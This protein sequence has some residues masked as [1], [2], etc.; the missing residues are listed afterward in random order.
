MAPQKKHVWISQPA[1]CTAFSSGPA[2]RQP[3]DR[4]TALHKTRPPQTWPASAAT[5]RHRHSGYP[6]TPLVSIGNYRCWLS[7]PGHGPWC[8]ASSDTSNRVKL[9]ACASALSRRYIAASR[10]HTI[11]SVATV[12]AT[13]NRRS[14]FPM[15]GHCEV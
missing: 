15:I 3:P 2:H 11:P 14:R 4:P 10:R 7:G 13:L 9:A 8:V 12:W 6:W 5:G 1:Q